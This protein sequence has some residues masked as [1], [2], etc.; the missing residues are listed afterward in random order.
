MNSSVDIPLFYQIGFVH[1]INLNPQQKEKR[2]AKSE[3]RYLLLEII[4]TKIKI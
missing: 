4:E 1:E 3:I 2:K